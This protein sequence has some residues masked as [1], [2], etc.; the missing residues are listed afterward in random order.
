M[1]GLDACC[2]HVPIHLSVHSPR[3]TSSFASLSPLAFLSYSS[4]SFLSSP[5]PSLTVHSSLTA[6]GASLPSPL[7]HISNTAALAF[8]L[9]PLS[10]LSLFPFYFLFRL[11]FL[12]TPPFLPAF[13]FLLS[14]TL[15]P[16]YSLPI[17]SPPVLSQFDFLSLMRRLSVL[18]VCQVRNN[19]TTRTHARTH[20]QRDG[21]Q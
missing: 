15:R 18:W 4:F 9:S 7:N 19:V 11:F 13:S 10:F 17:S 5:M 1:G 12:L 8:F 21:P 6:A 2:Y 20:T 14:Q 16:I 3:F